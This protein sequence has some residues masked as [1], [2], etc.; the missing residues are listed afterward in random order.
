VDEIRS[1]RA[2]Y[3]LLLF[4]FSKHVAAIRSMASVL[5][6]RYDESLLVLDQQ[7]LSPII[8]SL[9][10]CR[11]STISNCPLPS[12][13]SFLTDKARLRT[14]GPHLHRSSAADAIYLHPQLQSPS[15]LFPRPS[16]N[17][18]HHEPANAPRWTLHPTNPLRPRPCA[19][20]LRPHAL[21]HLTH[22]RCP[23]H[24]H[25][26]HGQSSPAADEEPMRL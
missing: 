18:N 25:H 17:S 11:V 21:L 7:E 4:F 24:H 14:R 5:Q 8:C 22:D 10:D 13:V 15:L 19:P 26:H 9:E 12:Y 2:L 20:C 16:S 6:H 3:E 1:T 23:P